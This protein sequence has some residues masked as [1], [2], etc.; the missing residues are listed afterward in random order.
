MAEE[1]V[2]TKAEAGDQTA[3]L[4][5]LVVEHADTLYRYAFRLTGAAADAEDLTQQTF[6]VA[7]RKM[8]QL[9]D[10][11]GARAWLMTVMRRTY[12]RSQTKNR[13]EREKMVPLDVE[14]LPA[15]EIADDWQIDRELLQSA[16]DELPDDFK[17]VLLGFYFEGLSYRE[18][19]E[20]FELPMGTVMSRLARAKSH[21][22]R[23]LFDSELESAAF[24]RS[25][26]HRRGGA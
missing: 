25:A 1:T 8:D 12:F 4:P 2:T 17:M 3:N 7:Q 24:S 20:Q 19:A 26:A 22:R 14:T 15:D 16:I 5:L 11:R 21:L 6:L 23:R 9:R 10:P 18:I 13:E